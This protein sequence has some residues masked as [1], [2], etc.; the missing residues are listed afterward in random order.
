M[1]DPKIY[2]MNDPLLHAD[3][4]DSLDAGRAEVLYSG[5]DGVMLKSGKDLY[6]ISIESEDTL[7][8]LCKMIDRDRDYD[9]VTHQFRLISAIYEEKGLFDILPCRQAVYRGEKLPEPEIPGIEF[10]PLTMEQLSFVTENYDS[11]ENYIKSRIEEGMLGAF[12]GE[13]CVGFIGRHGDGSLGLLKVLPAYR[14]RGI[15]EALESRMVN[16]VLDMGRV[17]YDHVV[18]GNDASMSLQKKLG[19]EFA[20]SMVVWLWKKD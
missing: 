10:R 9:I 11:S 8:R 18:I 17:P 14:R 12:D 5:E 7:R 16:R 4:L 6:R 1:R 13:K 15:G 19:M 2:L 3:M 20:K